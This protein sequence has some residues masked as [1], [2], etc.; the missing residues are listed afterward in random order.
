[1]T[2]IYKLIEKAKSQLGT[3]ESD[4]GDDKY[5]KWYGGFALTVAWCA[6][7]VSW[8]ADQCGLLGSI[9]PK[10]A[11][12][13]L[14]MKWFKDKKQWEDAPAHGG[15]YRPKKGDII[16][17]GI[18]GD[19]NHVG[20]VIDVN[21]TSV[22]TIEGNTSDMVATRTY[23]LKTS[24]ILGYGIPKYADGIDDFAEWIMELQ[25]L[26]K[27][28]VDGKPSTQLLE[29]T[30][31]LS[32]GS[33]GE[34]V[35]LVQKRLISLGYDLGRFGADGDFGNYT[36]TAVRLFQKKHVGLLKPDGELTSGKKSWRTLLKL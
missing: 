17:F 16:F 34:V 23:S 30:P 9:I 12:C 28:K 21:G 3:K 27:V 1:M 32:K 5:I 2:Q 22:Y 18:P 31:T 24:R 25:K 10:F 15:N 33:E 29:A 4:G 13:D 20:I 8:C 35:K 14:G 11:S 6:I 7:F 26:L 36:D 19:S